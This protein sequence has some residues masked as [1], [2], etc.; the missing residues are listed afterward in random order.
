VWGSQ[1]KM[2]VRRCGI[3]FNS[4]GSIRSSHFSY[5]NRTDRDDWQIGHEIVI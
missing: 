3:T 2:G 1:Q 4:V 5:G